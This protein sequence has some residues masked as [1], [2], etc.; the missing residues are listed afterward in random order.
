LIQV[1]IHNV[2]AISRP[3]ILPP[4]TPKERVEL[5][6]KAFMATMQDAEF[7]ADTEKAN[8][9]ISPLNGEEL[10]K[11][12]HSLVKVNPGLLGKLKQIISP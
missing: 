9:D 2:T 6:R 3:F 4:R 7:R 1:G 12:V 11:T 5:L 8:L 10:E